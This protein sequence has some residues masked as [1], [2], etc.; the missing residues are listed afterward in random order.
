MDERNDQRL[1]HIPIQEELKNSYLTYAMSV[2]VS[3]ALPDVRDGLKPSQRRIL[4]AM[5]DLNLGPRS[6]YRKCAKIAGDTSGNYHP[7]GEGIVYPTLVRLAQPF[8]MRAPL[9]DGQGN[10]GSLDGDPPAAMRYTE[11]RLTAITIEM[12]EDLDKNT[13]DFI[14]NYDETRT[15]P[16]VLPSKFPN[17]LV[18]GSL[19]IAV[20]MATSMP[21]NNIGEVCDGIIKVIEE[22]NIDVYDLCQI[23]KGPDFP[24]G[25]IVCGGA[26]ILRAYCQGRGV[27]ITRAKYN[28]E[29]SNNHTYIVFTEIPFQIN[30]AKILE[31]IASLVKED[32]VEGIQDIR[33]ESDRSHPVRIVVEVKKSE[34]AEVIA[35]Q[36][37]KYTSLESS[38]SIMMIALVDGRPELLN[39][40]KMVEY[41]IK[42]R[43]EVIRRKTQYLLQKSQARVEIVNALIKAIENINDTL[44]IIKNADDTA[45]ARMQ[46][47]QSLSLTE[48]QADAI[49]QIRLITLTHLELK[50]L[51][52]E[53]VSL[54]RNIQEYQNILANPQKILD[55][56]KQETA[57]I[58][59]QYAQPR[60]TEIIDTINPINM[61][62]V[63]PN[64]RCLV[65]VTGKGYV[66]RMSIGLYRNQKRGGKGILGVDM[67][68]DDFVERIFL[69]STHDYLFLVSN[70]GRAYW[71]KCYA[72]P[73]YGRNAKGRALVNLLNL[74]EGEQITSYIPVQQFNEQNLIMVTKKGV[75]KKTSL[76]VFARPNKGG[77]KAIMLDQGDQLVASLI[78]S[79]PQ[80]N[81][82][83]ITHNGRAIR[84]QLD[85][86]RT[87]GRVSRGVRG[88][89]LAENDYV[90]GV[91][92]I[93]PDEMLLTISEKGLGKRCDYS[94][95]RKGHRAAFGILCQAVKPKT[96]KIASALS[97]KDDHEI[98]AITSRGIIIRTDVNKLRE[99]NRVTQGTKVINLDE[100]DYVVSVATLAK[101][102]DDDELNKIESSPLSESTQ[103]ATPANDVTQQK[104][105]E[106]LYQ[107]DDSLD[108]HDEDNGQDEQDDIEE[109]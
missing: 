76:Q 1:L 99:L 100:G 5:N 68:N 4:V 95:F 75:V 34:Y 70:L 81:I 82:M 38:F 74:V 9:I 48:V 86:L 83:L 80:D 23:I 36:L 15:E 46:I 96:G 87:L 71:L 61:E 24:T 91:V 63:I 108:G 94:L 58:K 44:T 33:D 12:L 92:C 35:N 64:E 49:L 13:V 29:E 11:A 40:K 93:K 32:K 89:R 17:L 67:Q 51:F 79:D 28:I 88:C 85:D 98:M 57:D 54:N 107:D 26:P 103:P 65:L 106:H 30:K 105:R 52:E 101:Q 37:F 104:N 62:D 69:A 60:I 39:I 25:G 41:F 59:K 6:K 31:S 77:I 10:F 45:H 27:I 19:G 20:G 16:T 14:S 90:I 3:R 55:I 7:H 109:M 8:N 102:L 78:S 18:N 2:I 97:V 84:F 47:M 73:E 53:Q 21:P 43:Q 72:I 22:P 66:K 42:H 56:I 50:K